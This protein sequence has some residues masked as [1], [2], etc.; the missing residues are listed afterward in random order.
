[1]KKAIKSG[2]ILLAACST[3]LY[4][5]GTAKHSAYIEYKSIQEKSLPPENYFVSIAA[6]SSLIDVKSDIQNNVVLYDGAL[7]DQGLAFDLSFG[8]RTTPNIFFTVGYQYINLELAGIHHFYASANYQSNIKFHPYIGLILGQGRFIW[9]EE[10]AMVYYN[11]K[12][13]EDSITYGI[14]VGLEEKVTDK[15]SLFARYQAVKSDFNLEMYK[16]TSNIKHT[17][18][19]NIVIGANYAF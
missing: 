12:L 18:F 11:K 6:G 1:M 10:P 4:S 7:D 5:G 3:L 8:Y 14:Q 13:T 17:Q 19:N 15:V 2:V 16:N 9:D